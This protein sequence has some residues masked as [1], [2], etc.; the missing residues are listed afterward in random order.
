MK[1]EE[2]RLMKRISSMEEEMVDFLAE[3]I[4]IPALSPEN[5]GEGEEK[6]VERIVKLTGSWG[7]D[8]VERYDAP[9][10]RV[11]SG[12]RPNV[13]MRVAGREPGLP[14]WWVFVH[15]DVVPPGDLSLWKS[16]P[17]KLRREGDRLYGRGTEDNGQELV[18]SLFGLRAI[19]EEGLRPLR[20]VNI[21]L[22]ADEETGSEKGLRYL[23]RE[24][25]GLFRDD[26][27]YIVPDSGE[28]DGSLVEVAEKSI[29]W[30]RVTTLGK[31]VHA[32]T[33]AKGINAH[34]AGMMYALQVRDELKSRFSTVDLL[35][36][37]PS[38]T[39]EP[40]KKE[41]NVDN[42]NTIPGKDVLY[43]DCRVLPQY[44]LKDVLATFR[45]VAGQ[46]GSRTGAVIEVEPVQMQQAAPPTPPDSPVVN[47]IKE[48]AESVYGV[49]VRPGGIGGGTCAAI[50]REAGLP[51]AVWS[52]IDETAHMPNEYSLLP[53]LVGDAKVYSLLF[54]R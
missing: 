1:P 32:S 4:S 17:W 12:R 36:D 51:A 19:L 23:L 52:R 2:E 6:K 18:A 53:N 29:L 30:V 43:F 37:E 10:D 3:I 7:F 8:S 46:V 50:L 21:F 42:V 15:T 31:Q 38:S 20:D 54:L 25:R 35:Y 24:H 14:P 27:L 41:A 26:G 13:L 9:D 28:P 49:K 39:F 47:F 34:S 44:S 48:A 16:N 40:T 11:P 22:V 5:G 45:E 33:P